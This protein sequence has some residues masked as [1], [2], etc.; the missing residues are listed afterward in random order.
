MSKSLEVVATPLTSRLK[1][2]AIESDVFDVITLN[3]GSHNYTK[4][5]RKSKM[6][7]E[8]AW[9]PNCQVTYSR[10][11]LA[12]HQNDHQARRRFIEWA[13]NEIPVV[14]DFHKRILFSD[15]A[16]FWLNG[17]VNKQNCRIWSEANPQVYVETPLHPEKLTVWCAFGLVETFFK[18]DEGHKVTVNGNEI[19]K[20]TFVPLEAIELSKYPSIITP[21]PISSSRK[22]FNETIQLLRPS[23]KNFF[24][25]SPSLP[26]RGKPRITSTYEELR[27][28]H[29]HVGVMGKLGERGA[30][31]GVVL[32]T[33]LWFKTTSSMS[34][35][36]HVAEECDV[37][38][39]SLTHPMRDV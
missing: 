27:L 12:I 32:V 19:L 15:E 30:I 1:S 3:S 34:K 10:F 31:S 24:G 35:S 6:F 21:N 11:S 37:N 25:H 16:H 5:A 17:Y 8:S 38:N 14:P 2:E 28:K 7:L 29:P 22:L 18:N 33:G 36:L 39:H 9:N 13:Q 23:Y 20:R 4:L 26:S